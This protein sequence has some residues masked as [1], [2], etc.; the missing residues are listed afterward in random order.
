VIKLPG[1]TEFGLSIGLAAT[2]DAS[3]SLYSFSV[4]FSSVGS[5][6]K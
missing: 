6:N 1:P 5:I 4:I 2:N 3:I